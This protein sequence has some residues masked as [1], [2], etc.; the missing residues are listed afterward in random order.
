MQWLVP[1]TAR[2]DNADKVVAMEPSYPVQGG[3]SGDMLDFYAVLGSG[4]N[5]FPG[6]NLHNHC[7]YAERTTRIPFTH[8]LVHTHDWTGVTCVQQ[9]EMTLLLDMVEPVTV[10][11]GGCYWMPA[12]RYMTGMN[13]GNVTALMWDLYAVPAETQEA[14][15]Y[16]TFDLLPIDSRAASKDAEEDDICRAEGGVLVDGATVRPLSPKERFN[17]SASLVRRIKEICDLTAGTLEPLLA[18]YPAC[19]CIGQFDETGSVEWAL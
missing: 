11:E 13:T 15:P 1:T 6:D 12:G 4:R 7:L 5:T 16:T 9:G 18:P 10:R 8:A 14:L 2:S 17:Q 3:H 19:E